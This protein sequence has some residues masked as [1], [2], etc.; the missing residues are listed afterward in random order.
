MDDK[1]TKTIDLQVNARNISDFK[2]GY[3]LILKD[4][5]INP[6]VLK[7]EG[8]IVRLIDRNR[9]IRCKRLLWCTKQRDWLG[10]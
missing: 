9:Q 7:K 3:P 2:K 10:A 6:D 8:S 1:M 5:I 4:A